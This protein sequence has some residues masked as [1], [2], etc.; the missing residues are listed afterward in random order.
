M[1]SLER[2]AHAR[3]PGLR[4]T[5]CVLHWSRSVLRLSLSCSVWHEAC[6]LLSQPSE[7]GGYL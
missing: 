6:Y 7:K 2:I 5:V 1:F 4:N 3:L